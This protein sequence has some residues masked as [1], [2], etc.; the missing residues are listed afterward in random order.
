[1]RRPTG[2]R[3]FFGQPVTPCSETLQLIHYSCHMSNRKLFKSFHGH[4]GFN[5]LI[6]VLQQV[7]EM[8]MYLVFSMERRIE[9]I[10]VVLEELRVYADEIGA[11]SR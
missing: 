8:Q 4:K 3:F 6:E 7:R 5:V 10:K 9:K 2:R 11:N 1:M